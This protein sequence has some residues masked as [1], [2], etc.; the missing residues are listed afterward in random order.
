MQTQY[1]VNVTS[2]AHSQSIIDKFKGVQDSKSE[3]FRVVKL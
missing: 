3:A 1:K 2:T